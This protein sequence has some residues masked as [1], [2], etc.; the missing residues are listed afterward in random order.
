[1]RTAEATEAVAAEVFKQAECSGQ[2][3]SMSMINR[4]IEQLRAHR[5]TCRCGLCGETVAKAKADRVFVTASIWQRSVIATR[6]RA[7]R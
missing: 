5:P 3:V 2:L 6:A 7:V 4:A 1:M